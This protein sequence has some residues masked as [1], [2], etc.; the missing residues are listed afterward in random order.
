[1]ARRVT[2][3]QA[4]HKEDLVYTAVDK[5]LAYHMQTAYTRSKASEAIN[6]CRPFKKYSIP[7][8]MEL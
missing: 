8:K 1:M 5:S 7:K 3:L 2:I 4:F 6:H